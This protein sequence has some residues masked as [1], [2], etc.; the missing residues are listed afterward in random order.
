LGPK[1]LFSYYRKQWR[2]NLIRKYQAFQPTLSIASENL[3]LSR[4]NLTVSSQSAPSSLEQDSHS[5][6]PT[7]SI[8]VKEEEISEHKENEEIEVLPP[9]YDVHPATENTINFISD[10][11]SKHFT[12]VVSLSRLS[13][14][15]PRIFQRFHDYGLF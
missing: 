3:P 12:R 5:L 1:S 4:P 13:F 15:M 6:V 14:T 9:V 2:G 7:Q 10:S 8:Q 11:K